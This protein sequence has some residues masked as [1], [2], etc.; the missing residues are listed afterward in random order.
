MWFMLYHQ[1]TDPPI[2]R[3]FFQVKDMRPDIILICGP[4]CWKKMP[5]TVWKTWLFG[6][7]RMTSGFVICPFPEG[8]RLNGR[9]CMGMGE[10]RIKKP[11]P[12]CI[13]GDGLRNWE[14]L[15]G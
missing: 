12:G 2:L 1:D 10:G 15:F 4:K 14:F 6:P 11:G 13:K 7:K 8:I 9:R 5:M 3:I